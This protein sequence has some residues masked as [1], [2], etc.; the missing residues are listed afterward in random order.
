MGTTKLKYKPAE[1]YRASFEPEQAEFPIL[2]ATIYG[3][4]CQRV[5]R[6]IKD[7]SVNLVLTSPPYNLGKAYEECQTV[8]EYLEQ[9]KPIAADLVRVLHARGSLCF[10]IGNHISD[11]EVVPLDI[12]FYNLFSTLGL[13]LRSRIIWTFEH[14]LHS[15]RRFSGRYEVVLWFTKGHDY[16]FNLD[17]V[18]VP[19]KYPGKR[20][21]KGPNKG[22]PSCNPLGKNP[23]D[24]WKFL[25]REW[26]EEV[27]SIPN[28]KANHPE[29]TA[30]P[31]QYPIELAERFVLAL[32]KPGDM[33][34]DPFA[35]AGTTVIASLM[36]HRNA[37]ACEKE[38]EYVR[39]IESRIKQLKEQCAPY[40]PIG[41]P[42]QFASGKV[43]HLPIE[44]IEE[45]IKQ[46]KC[47]NDHCHNAK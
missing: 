16:V 8:E 44:W 28:V 9:Y 37:L 24:L 46:H 3:G 33:V 47:D 11:G 13:K 39:I 41:K 40:R 5:L 45:L 31:C 12:L 38:P 34:L 6:K 25:A 43:S 1:V 17:N 29:K 26:E 2:E 4:Q 32:T 35:G 27:W 7:E 36:N 18:R 20:S 15:S 19:P 23:G 21:Y 22:K 14:G 42:I 30:H 10:Q